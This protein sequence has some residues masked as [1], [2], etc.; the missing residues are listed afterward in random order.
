MLFKSPRLWEL[1]AA[2]IENQS[3][4]RLTDRARVMSSATTPR[5]SPDN[6]RRGTIELGLSQ[7]GWW[8]P[9]HLVWAISPLRHALQRSERILWTRTPKVRMLWK[10][11][12]NVTLL[13]M[14]MVSGKYTFVET[15]QLYA[16]N[17]CLLL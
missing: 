11:I 10:V 9:G 3:K 1:A 4:S 16:L 13:I 2:A 12:N 8:V 17:I 7:Q 6:Q 14:P 15:H 5:N